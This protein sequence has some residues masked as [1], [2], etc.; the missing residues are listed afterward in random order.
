MILKR[1]GEEEGVVASRVAE[2]MVLVMRSV[3]SVDDRVDAML[4]MSNESLGDVQDL[5]AEKLR[6]LRE[7]VLAA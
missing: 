6:A 7:A 3:A 1:A 4:A 2:G 5:A